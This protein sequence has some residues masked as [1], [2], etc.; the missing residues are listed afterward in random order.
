MIGG[1]HVLDWLAGF[2]LGLALGI[3]FTYLVYGR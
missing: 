1:L 3:L 2:G